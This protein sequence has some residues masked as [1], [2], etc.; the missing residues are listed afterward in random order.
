MTLIVTATGLAGFL[1][2]FFMLHL[3]LERMWLKYPLAVALAYAVFLVL[4][5]LWIIYQER[6]VAED[7][8]DLCPHELSGNKSRDHL[9]SG[10][11]GGSSGWCDIA[12]GLDADE[13]IVL[14]VFLLALLTAL[15]ASIF[16]VYSAPALLGEVFLD[17]V[18]VAALRKKMIRITEQHWSWG[19]MRRTVLPFLMIVL[20]FGLAGAT[21]QHIKPEAR[22]IGGIFHAERPER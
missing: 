18:L 4:L 15:L 16:I 20:V 12:S 11:S 2:S 14:L 22:S 6:S 8:L 7:L 5:K 19:V 1:A 17:A 21:M 13:W 10:D 9:V 3:G